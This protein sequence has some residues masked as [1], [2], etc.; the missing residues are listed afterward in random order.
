MTISAAQSV[1]ILSE[2]GSNLILSEGD[3]I[4]VN[5]TRVQNNG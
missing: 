3:E 2:S 4:L 5:G 1:D